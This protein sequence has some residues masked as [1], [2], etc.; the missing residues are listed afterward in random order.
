MAH[1]LNLVNGRASM[2]YYGELPWHKLGR[3]LDN[4]AT[5]EEAIVAAGLDF[6]VVK[7][8]LYY[9]FQEAIQLTTRSFATVRTDTGGYLGTVGKRYEVIQNKNAFKAI[10]TLIGSKDAIYHTAGALGQ[11][12]RVWILAKL[13]DFIRIR[14]TNDIIEKYFLLT[15]SHD[16]K[17]GLVMKTTPIRVVCNNTLSAALRGTEQFI[18]I[19][20]TINADAHMQK[21][22]E[23]LGI[24]NSV[25]T[26]LDQIFNRMALRKITTIELLN[27]V[28]TLIPDPIDVT[29]SKTRS[30]NMRNEVL[31]LVEVGAGEN[32]VSAKGTLWGAYNGFTEAVDHI[33]SNKFNPD[34]HALST[35]FGNGLQKKD[36]A[37]QLAISMLN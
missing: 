7:T 32:L 8:P 20:H 29:V 2:M 30:Q 17:S 14:D 11:G 36:R 34:K 1:N 3:K 9:N 21:G 15:N 28:K 5:S 24:I 25:Y 18:S 6:E 26:Q 16:G 22:F 12:E 35:M 4:P 19:R 10:D 33:V 23:L 13:P 37:F 31:E 27:Y